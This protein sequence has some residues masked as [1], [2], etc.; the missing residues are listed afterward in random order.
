VPI[1]EH[2]AGVI[3]SNDDA[4]GI[5]VVAAC[6]PGAYAKSDTL[7]LIAE[8]HGKRGVA[9]FLRNKL[10]TKKS[11]RSGDLGE[12]LATAY[13][14]DVSGCMVG[15]SRLIFRDHQEWAMRGDDVL[16]AK[17]TPDGK[18]HITKAESKSR[19][20]V[21]ESTVKEAREGLSRNDGFPS[22]HSLAQFADRL[23][24][25]AD[26]ATGLAIV[27]MQ[28]SKGIRPEDVSHLMF[29]LTGSDPSKH[30]TADLKAYTGPFQQ[31]AI[32]FRVQRHQQFIEGVYE[33]VITNGS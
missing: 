1:G 19:A 26:E 32:T 27:D 8:K 25:T 2:H 23:M 29:L 15:P 24:S 17:V 13:L 10:P 7:A 33:R 14:R 30:V 31:L 28:I 6:L 11:A 4:T 18:V 5:A 22:P 3:E 21:G 12:I 16:G 9:S 20:T